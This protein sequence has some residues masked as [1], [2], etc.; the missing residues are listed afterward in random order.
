MKRSILFFCWA[1]F[2]LIGQAQPANL[3]YTIPVGVALKE[4]PAEITLSQQEKLK[5]KIKQLLTKNGIGAEN[6]EQEFIVYPIIEIYETN[7]INGYKKQTAVK[8]EFSL[9]LEQANNQLLFA[10][11]SKM[12]SG[13]G[14]NKELAI[15]KAINSIKSN[16]ASFK[17]FLAEGRQK[18]SHYYK[19]NCVQIIAKATAHEQLTNYGKA[20]Y[21]LWK[22]PVVADCYSEVQ[23]QMTAAYLKFQQKHCQD[24]L[25]KAKAA[26]AARQYGLSLHYLRRID[27]AS[28]CFAER[29]QL[30]TAIKEHLSAEDLKQWNFYKN[31]YSD[32][33]ELEKLRLNA[34]VEIA[35]AYAE[36]EGDKAYQTLIIK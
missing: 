32:N 14:Q 10:S 34:M 1:I 25:Q 36:Q 15:T 27:S 5:N 26:Q 7:V 30:I 33:I 23:G 28:T 13:V 19:E 22:I 20:I 12:L 18:I 2:C 9:Y 31:T 29:N 17:K 24:L 4:I 21:E 8:L 3:S 35:K 6:W 11:T 16:D